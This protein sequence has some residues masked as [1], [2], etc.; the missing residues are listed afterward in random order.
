MLQSYP[1]A[2]C[3]GKAAGDVMSATGP[4][5]DDDMIVDVALSVLIG[6]RAG[7]LLVRDEDGRCMGLI[8]RSQLTAHRQG[9][10][11]TEETRLRDLI[12]D[13]GPFTS[14]V[15]P[16]HDAERAMRQ[17]A[18]RASPVIGEDGHALGVVVLTH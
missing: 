13:R 15:T 7:Y 3:S 4:Q 1:Q 11:Y 10:W 8:T 6:A 14:P 12:Y 16:A 2:D 9:S 5:V 18:L 17:R